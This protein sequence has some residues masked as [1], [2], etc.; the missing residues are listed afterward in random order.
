LLLL[1]LFKINR[2]SKYLVFCLF[3]A[4]LFCFCKKQKLKTEIQIIHT[5][6]NTKINKSFWLNKDTGFFCGG[7]KSQS[8]Y[9]YKTTDAG[10]SWTNT[11]TGEEKSLYDV[12]FVNDTLGYCCGENMQMLRTINSGNSWQSIGKTTNSN[13]HYYGTL[14]GIFG[15]RDLLLFAGGTNFNI[16]I[17]T[18]IVKDEVMD[19]FMG[20]SNE[21]RSG[22]NFGADN[23]LA[24]GYGTSYRTIDNALTFSPTTFTGDFF[25]SGSVINNSTGYACS[26]NGAIYKISNSG[27]DHEKIFDLN[28]PGKKHINFNGLIFINENTGWVVGNEG[29][30]YRTTDGKNFTAID[31]QTKNNLLSIAINKNNEIIISTDN[32]KLL[33]FSY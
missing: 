10:L 8:G 31:S 13:K 23:Y 22:F 30:I 5:P 25:T 9:I 26:Y 15:N 4:L 16:G 21:M 14:R 19:G 33:K 28:S 29:V 20:L 32:G 7:E 24:C 17:I 2:I 3:S 18:R 12:F 11:F 6:V 1:K 27:A